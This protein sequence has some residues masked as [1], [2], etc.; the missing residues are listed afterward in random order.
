MQY[1]ES[2]DRAVEFA[3]SAMALMAQHRVAPNPVNIT[4]WYGYFAGRDPAM[5]RV[6]DGLL[7]DEAEI[8]SE[9]CEEIYDK[10]IGFEEE[11]GTL[12]ETSDRLQDSMSQVLGYIGEAG[13]D[14]SDYGEKLVGISS[15]LAS[16]NSAEEAAAL[17]SGI[18]GETGKLIEKNKALE[19]RL[20]ASSQEI[21][22][23]NQHLRQT[24][25]E[26]MTD[27][28]TGI[29]NRKYFDV[30]LHEETKHATE[31]DSI[32]CLLLAEVDN[33]KT[34]KDLYGHVIGDEV[35]RFV[36]RLFRQGIKGR[37]TLA[38]YGGEEFAVLLP[39]T[40][41]EDSI[42]VANKLRETIASHQLK[43]KKT[44][45][46]YG[47]VNMS[48]GVSNYR[49]GETLE[50]FVQRAHQALYQAKAGGQSCV[51]A[52]TV[53]DRRAADIG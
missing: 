38:R 41:L 4:L 15:Q 11:H 6:L 2:Y 51:V 46:R 1:V 30:A 9:R 52:E 42:T 18:L 22:E 50:D 26:A 24:R 37:D 35:L 33:F 39:Q 3:K 28:L 25:R 40:H 8:T 32:L 53:P 21:D 7:Q 12:R 31:D 23:L 19:N 29:A 36:A 14:H 48:F 44:G 20:A 43:N 10:Y 17:V 5:N 34:F 13:K 47:A 49:P 45:E 16:S 27:P